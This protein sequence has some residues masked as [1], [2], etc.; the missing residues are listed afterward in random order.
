M[1][2]TRLEFE[3]AVSS[4][5]R[6][7]PEKISLIALDSVDSTN[8][9]AKTLAANGAPPTIVIA[10]GQT[11]GRGRLG[12]PFSSAAGEGVY[13]SYLFYPDISPDKISRLTAGAA[14]ATAECIEAASGAECGIKWVNDVFIANKKIC[15]ILTEG[16]FSPDGRL[17]YAII[18]VG[19]NLYD[20]DFGE[21]SEVASSIERETGVRPEPES[22]LRDLTARLISAAISPDVAGY[23]RR[24]TIVGKR[25]RVIGGGS[26][27][28]AEAV[29]IND[30]CH[31]IVKDKNGD[32]RELSSGEIS[33]KVT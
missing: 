17:A 5:R 13:L 29:S 14:V 18:G 23:K 1:G 24:S 27:Y 22:F 4:L 2:M 19:V 7:L 8:S 15:G 26:E 33:V 31:L 6:S 20:R 28:E 16:A 12:R 10:R 11:G 21:L 25:V 32:L 3:Q 30:V 9:Y